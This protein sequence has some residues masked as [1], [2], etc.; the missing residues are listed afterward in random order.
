MITLP[1]ASALSSAATREVSNPP[2]GSAYSPLKLFNAGEQGF[3]FDPNDLSTLFQDSAGTTPVTAAGQPVGLMLDKRLGLI[4]GKDIAGTGIERS[5]GSLVRNSF[6]DFTSTATSFAYL[7]LSIPVSPVP[8]ILVFNWKT[9]NNA[10]GT[11]RA[12]VWNEAG[13]TVLGLGVARGGDG[14]FIE[15]IYVPAGAASIRAAVQLNGAAGANCKFTV[16]ARSMPGNHATQP[17][18]AGRPILREE[19]GVRYLELDGIDDGML[20]AG[21]RADVNWSS[22]VAARKSSS[23]GAF[24]FESPVTAANIYMGSGNNSVAVNAAPQNN[25][26]SKAIAL[27]ADF[28]YAV[29]ITGDNAGTGDM[30]LFCRYDGTNRSFYFGGR[31]YGMLQANKIMT[32][33]QLVQVDKFMSGTMAPR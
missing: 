11:S 33:E 31:V 3:W 19:N 10:G 1:I 6:L 27:N 16:S 25:G 8:Y 26:F 32:P 29:S 14:S 18:Q 30:S 24:L 15:T 20:I 2:R 12:F 23:G 22:G 17:S 9:T 5:G 13:F 28:T 7:A 21:Y 4:K